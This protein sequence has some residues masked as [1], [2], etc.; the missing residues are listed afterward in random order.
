MFIITHEKS[1]IYF[2]YKNT[3]RNLQCTQ[4]TYNT[5]ETYNLIEKKYRKAL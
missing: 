3:I 4:Y 5:Q 1:H 2:V